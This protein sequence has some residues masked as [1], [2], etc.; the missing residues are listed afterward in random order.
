MAQLMARSMAQLMAEESR[1]LVNAST[2]GDATAVEKL[3]C[4]H[5]D[6]LRAYIRLRAGPL[7]TAK[8]S[9]G[10]LVQSVCREVLQDLDTFRYESDAH[11]KH[12]L[13]MSALRKIRDRGRYDRR[14]RRDAAREV[15]PMDT[16]G[17]EA[18]E[19]DAGV[20]ASYATMHTPS[21]DAVVQEEIA[22]FERA[23][24]ELSEE[25]QEVITLAR[26]M[27]MPHAEIAVRL[28]KS[29]GAVRVLLHRALARLAARM[30]E[31]G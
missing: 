29:E 6:G 31:D 5:L 13:Y 7:V 28:D 25:Q 27:G 19:G 15:A 22:C 4:R 20:L 21:R 26:M 1:R 9:T 2:G 8:E 24:R 30:R 18:I 14:Q 12:W 11:F 23:F 10:D 3:L 16:S 17:I